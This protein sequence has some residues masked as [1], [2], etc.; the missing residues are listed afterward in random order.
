MGY[1]IN[2]SKIGI[3]R[4][5][6]ILR[7]ED[8]IPSWQILLDELN[9]KMRKI[10]QLEIENLQDLRA[11]IKDKKHIQ[12]VAKKTG[13][14]IE[15]LTVLR[16]AVNGY[17]RKPNRIADLPDTSPDIVKKLEDLGIK[18]TRQLF[19]KIK[20]K[21]LR[22]E[23]SAEARI[24]EKE[25]RRLAE[26]TDLSRIQWTNHTFAYVLM[27]AG[28]PTA[29]AVANAEPDILLNEVN[30]LATERN[31]F[32]A[33]LGLRDMTRLVAAAKRVSPEIEW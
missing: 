6:E 23:L 21:Q 20:T 16:R 13:I 11:A 25:I 15:Y 3:Q 27:E 4:F 30:Q 19:D 5:K 26:L 31:L 22:K 33:H 9:E 1:D 14:S 32:P 10:Q 17:V 8:L 2:L 28:Y 24:S 12:D 29:E 18:H 7:A